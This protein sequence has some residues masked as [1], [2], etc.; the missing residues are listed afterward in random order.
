MA[1]QTHIVA[2]LYREKPAMDF[3]DIVDEFE[4]SLRGTNA[5]RRRLTYDYDDLVIIDS[6][7][8]RVGLAW[9]EPETPDQPWGL[10]IATGALTEALG[11]DA[12]DDWAETALP[13]GFAAEL[14]ETVLAR[15][16]HELPFDTA[17]R[18]TLNEPLGS[19]LLDRVA[20]GLDTLMPQAP[21][22][23]EMPDATSEADTA[24][25]RLFD[26]IA[27]PLYRATPARAPAPAAAIR[28]GGAEP[29]AGNP[30]SAVDRL[31]AA[32]A[33]GPSGHGARVLGA[34]GAV[35]RGTAQL[36]ATSRDRPRP[37]RAPTP[38]EK[39]NRYLDRFDKAEYELYGH[40]LD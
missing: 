12:A 26:D 13:E 32:Y 34:L 10:V 33:A 25:D 3:D 23:T 16:G 36:W 38:T 4:L 19:D 15:L 37:L 6:P 2:A 14:G 35:A 31:R 21:V 8:L 9:V 22:Q 39:V 27:T 28:T 18:A 17:L 1:C 5:G 20:S 29:A 24:L 7:P 30:Q 11:D 40:L